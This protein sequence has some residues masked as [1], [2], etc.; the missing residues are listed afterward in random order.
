MA[1]NVGLGAVPALPAPVPDGAALHAATGEPQSQPEPTAACA[2]GAT[3][4]EPVPSQH[5]ESLGVTE[6]EPEPSQHTESSASSQH[7]EPPPKVLVTVKGIDE[8]LDAKK[9]PYINYTFGLSIGPDRVHT[10]KGRYSELAKTYNRDWKKVLP[11]CNAKFPGK[12]AGVTGSKDMKGGDNVNINMR[13]RELCEFFNTI[14]VRRFFSSG[15]I[16]GV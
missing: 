6:Q 2:A 1:E 12:H 16:L 10:I 14:M 5:T 8:E 7:P 4:P 9:K 15:F 3:E 11:G 13:S